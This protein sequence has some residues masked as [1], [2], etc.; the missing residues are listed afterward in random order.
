MAAGRFV[1]PLAYGTFGL[2]CLT[3]IVAVARLRAPA[4][5]P[6]F[7][8]RKGF[9]SEVETSEALHRST[10]RLEHPG[11]GRLSVDNEVLAL[12]ESRCVCALGHV[13]DHRSIR[14]WQILP[15]E[16]RNFR[17]PHLVLLL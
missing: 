13:H 11:E 9:V 4:T 15:A 7:G 14:L 10:P 8:A 1:G 2:F 5:N 16:S 12:Q 6:L 3:V 17:N